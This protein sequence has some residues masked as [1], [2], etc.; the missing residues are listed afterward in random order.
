MCLDLPSALGAVRV[1]VPKVGGV[2][3]AA[4]RKKY[5]SSG[6]RGK[7]RGT[8]RVGG[9]GSAKAFERGWQVPARQHLFLEAADR[10]EIGQRLPSYSPCALPAALAA[11]QHLTRPVGSEKSASGST[12]ATV[13]I[14]IY[15]EYTEHKLY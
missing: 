2:P 9:E 14:K 7:L 13:P 11:W 15:S 1:V 10:W 12:D 3:S 5:H 4:V 6:A 8:T